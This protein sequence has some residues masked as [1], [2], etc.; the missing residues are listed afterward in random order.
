[1]TLL[2][3]ATPPDKLP[4]RVP[5]LLLEG[6]AVKAQE[7]S[8]KVNGVPAAITRLFTN[9]DP[10]LLL[11]VLDLAGDL[12]RVDPARE[13]LAAELAQ[14]PPNVSVGLL[15]AQD[16][17]Q[18]LEDPG[19]PREKLAVLIRGLSISGR[20]GLLDTTDTVARLGDAMLLKS[21]V[22]TAVLFISDSLITN[23]REDYTNPVVNSSDAN[24]MSRR[25]PEGLVKEK[26]RQLR[27]ELSS[28]LTP[29]FLV[30][31][32]YRSDRLNEAYQ[33]G[34]L[35][36]FTSSGGKAI[37]CR[38]IGEIPAAIHETIETLMTLQAVEVEPKPSRSKQ[39]QILLEAPGR[40]FHYRTYYTP[41]RVK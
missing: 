1:M 10:L 22:R 9:E 32:N 15:R 33:S 4:V 30:H 18:V 2:W 29:L 35:D 27:T 16:G 3:G 13:S 31:V 7:I 21:R 11:V 28:T 6:E 41:A 34:L 25:F 20:A 12:S 17:L 40:R 8:A 5:F 14:L 36:L 37:F 24:D 38:S 26:I 39:W 19:T 23:Y